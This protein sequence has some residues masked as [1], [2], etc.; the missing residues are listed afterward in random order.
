MIDLADVTIRLNSA[1]EKR[2]LYYLFGTIT[3]PLL[4]FGVKSVYE[5]YKNRQERQRTLYADALSACMEY[6]E[7]VF[8]IYR[9]GKADP[10]A[11]RIRISEALRDVQ[12]R[13]AHYQAW[14]ETES[15]EVSK[16]YNALVK[17]MR[18]VAGK[19]M[20]R[21]WR[22]PPIERDD[23]MIITNHIDWEDLGEYEARFTLA[24][25]RELSSWWVRQTTTD[26]RLP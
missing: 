25:R 9:R 2:A 12:K 3:V 14:L 21:A 26:W 10:E 16:T 8:V 13:I 22:T 18:E 23:Q 24:V 11:E 5:G 19:E 1:T 20:K 4:L 17:R 15:A 7:F 6:K